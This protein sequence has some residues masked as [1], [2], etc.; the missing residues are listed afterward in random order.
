MVS[1]GTGS[2]SLTPFSPEGRL[3]DSTGRG[4]TSPLVPSWVTLT[5]LPTAGVRVTPGPLFLLL[6]VPP[7]CLPCSWVLFQAHRTLHNLPS[8]GPF[9][10]KCLKHESKSEVEQLSSVLIWGNSVSPARLRLLRLCLSHCTC[11]KP[12]DAGLTRAAELFRI[13]GR[14]RHP[15]LIANGHPG[16]T[17]EVN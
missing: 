9:T 11:D 7:D 6:P 13:G 4:L 3:S 12:W 10:S 5:M 16:S 15:A 17:G 8:M 14:A 1:C 2:T